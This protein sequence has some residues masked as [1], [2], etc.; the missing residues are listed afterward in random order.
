MYFYT[1]I[2]TEQIF[3]VLERKRLELGLS[4]TEVSARAF[5]RAENSALQGIRRGA[6]PSVQKLEALG[7]EFR[8]GEPSPASLNQP[9][10]VLDGA[11][12]AHIPVHEAS[13]S[14][15]P[16]RDNAGSDITDHL[17]FRPDWLQRIGVQATK[18]CLARVTGHSMQPTLW[19]GDMVLID[20]A[21]TDPVIRKRTETCP[22][23][24]PQIASHCRFHC[25]LTLLVVGKD[26][27]QSI[28][29]CISYSPRVRMFPITTPTVE[30]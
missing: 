11:D 4:Q 3:S 10:M 9:S 22:Q 18:A 16:V 15:G 12:H 29:R 26:N 24:I 21:K 1:M 2:T 30:R 13:L 17:A 5:G 23:P 28:R 25:H 14:A 27:L 7:L 19:P 20:Q 8:F 6:M